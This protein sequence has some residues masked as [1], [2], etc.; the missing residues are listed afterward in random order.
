MRNYDRAAEIG[1]NAE[2]IERRAD[3]RDRSAA[4]LDRL[5][6]SFESK[7]GGAHLIV[8][9]DGKTVDFWPGTGKFIQRQSGARHGRGVFNL[10][11][12]LGIQHEEGKR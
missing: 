7:N 5:G 1:M 3:N 2:S 9:H 6:V 10:M 11:K 8:T 4:I 12:L